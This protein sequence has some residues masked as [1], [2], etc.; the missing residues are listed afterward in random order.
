MKKILLALMALLVI[1][2]PLAIAGPAT[3]ATSSA[4]TTSAANVA[5]GH[6]IRVVVN[7]HGSKVLSRTSTLWQN[8]HR[9]YDWSPKPGLYKVKSE[10]RYQIK[11]TTEKNVWVPA[12]YCADYSRDGYDHNDDGDFADYYDD[13]PYDACADG[14]Y[15]DWDYRTVTKLSTAKSVTRYNY[16]RVHTDE[17]PGCV[18][19]A[20]YRAVKDG[21]T[22]RPACTACSAPRAT[23]RTTGR[24]APPASTAPAPVT[25]TTPTCRWTTTPA[26]GSSGSTSTSPDPP[27]PQTRPT[28]PPGE[29]CNPDQLHG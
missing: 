8:G 28:I 6:S 9:V 16:V 26:S 4:P 20:E 10:I 22:Q 15:G 23:S 24:A 7:A 11:T 17:T 21:M 14:E 1:G 18:S 27:R 5:R 12:G 29:P 25:R 3:A 19:H 13:T 2:T